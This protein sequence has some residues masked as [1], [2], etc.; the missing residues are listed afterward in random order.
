MAGLDRAGR[1]PGAAR[2]ARA[3]RSHLAWLA[4]W[5]GGLLVAGGWPRRARTAGRRRSAPRSRGRA[6]MRPWSAAAR[7]CARRCRCSSRR[8]RRSPASP[9]ASRTASTPSGSSILAECTPVSR[10]SL[11]RASRGRW[12]RRTRMRAAPS[13]AVLLG[14]GPAESRAARRQTGLPGRAD[15]DV[16]RG[17][18]G[19]LGPAAGVPRAQ[20]DRGDQRRPRQ[21]PGHRRAAGLRG[22]GLGRLRAPPRLRRQRQ[23][24][25]G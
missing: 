18:A 17:Q 24:Q 16:C 19:G 6:G 14:G 13:V 2:R 25:P 11:T 1:R 8:R 5:G 10:L 15:E 23:R 7:R 4:D 22:P 12:R 21:R 3:R 20:P 9:R